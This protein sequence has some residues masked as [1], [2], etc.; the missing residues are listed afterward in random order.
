MFEVKENKAK[1]AGK[2]IGFGIA[3]VVFTSVF[4]YIFSKFF[5][6]LNLNIYFI[7]I[8]S[9]IIIYIIYVIIKNQKNE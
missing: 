6:V 5:D 8:A 2:I 1:K 7:I 4:Y 9:I 3:M